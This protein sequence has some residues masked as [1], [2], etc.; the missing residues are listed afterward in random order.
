[1]ITIV[2]FSFH[3]RFMIVWIDLVIKFL[4]LLESNEI[5]KRGF[6][7]RLLNQHI[8]FCNVMDRGC[9]DHHCGQEIIT[10]Q[11]SNP[12]SPIKRMGESL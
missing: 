7:T 1:M 2:F 12:Q 4:D 5:N 11:S 10:N 9:G 6:A 3:H 8:S